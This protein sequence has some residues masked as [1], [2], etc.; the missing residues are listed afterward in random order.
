MLF[1]VYYQKEKTYNPRRET[2]R[3]L[4]IKAPSKVDVIKRIEKN[5]KYNIEYI[6]LKLEG[7]YLDYEKKH[8]D[9]KLVEY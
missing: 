6:T 1:K 5:T 2:T 4:Y 9:F 8:A 3:S 7:K